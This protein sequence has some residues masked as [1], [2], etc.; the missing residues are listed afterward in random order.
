[1][2]REVIAN[3]GMEHFAEIGLVIFVAVFVLI[4]LRALFMN[5]EHSTQMGQMPLDGGQ[6]PGNTDAEQEVST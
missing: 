4:I 6:K 1:M 5:K 3:S 2:E